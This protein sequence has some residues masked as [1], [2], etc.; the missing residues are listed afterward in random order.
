MQ[1]ELKIDGSIPKCSIQ[2]VIVPF[3]ITFKCTDC[4]MLVGYKINLYSRQ[5][6]MHM[7]HSWIKTT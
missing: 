2:S 7:V 1:K 5:F 6:S 4:I 3:L